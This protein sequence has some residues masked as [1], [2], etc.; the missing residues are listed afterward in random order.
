MMKNY[1]FYTGIFCFIS[2]V[3][4]PTWALANNLRVAV[5]A[6]FYTTLQPIAKAYEKSVHQHVDIIKGSTGKLYAQIINGAPFDVFM[7]AD[8]ERPQHLEQAGLIVSGSRYTFAIGQL[9]L[10]EPHAKK[11]ANSAMSLP[12]Q[13]HDELLKGRFTRLAIANPETAP[14]GKAAIEVLRFL[15]LL[16]QVQPK[17]V[18]GE[19]IAQAYQFVQSGNASMGFV[20]LSYVKKS[21]VKESNAKKPNTNNKDIDYWLPSPNLYSSLE[22]QLVILKSSKQISQAQRFVSFLQQKDTKIFIQ[23]QGYLMP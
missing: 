10:W 18:Y 12:Q 2:F 3:L 14:Y 11:R 22:Q 19:N 23:D 21:Y 7:A 17:L 9:A 13:I 20:A 1:I 6:N 16:K 15:Y 5:A 4:S 8:V